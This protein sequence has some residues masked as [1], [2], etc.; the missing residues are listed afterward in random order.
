[1]LLQAGQ[2]L[3]TCAGFFHSLFLSGFSEGATRSTGKGRGPSGIEI[4]GWDGDLMELTFD[5][6]N[7]TRAAFE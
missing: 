1:M 6:P 4:D 3:T 7:I 2:Q 5:D